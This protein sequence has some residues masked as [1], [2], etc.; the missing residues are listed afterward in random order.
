MGKKS[1]V[2]I[3]LIRRNGHEIVQGKQLGEAEFRKP[4]F[5]LKALPAI[6]EKARVNS[7]DVGLFCDG[8]HI[9]SETLRAD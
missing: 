6:V 4:E 3:A 7:T 9:P 5:A 1:K 2:V 8:K